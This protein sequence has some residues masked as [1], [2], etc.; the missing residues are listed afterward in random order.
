MAKGIIRFGLQYIISNNSTSLWDKYVLDDTWMEFKM[1]AANYNTINKK[2]LFTDIIK[3]NPAAEKLH[4]AVS[5]AAI[6]YI[7][8]L[9][10][11]MPGVLNAHGK[12]LV[13]F[14]NFTFH[15]IQSD[16][17]DSSLHKV[18]IIFISEP[19]TLID[20]FNAHY[21]IT[22][23]DKQTELKEGKEVPTEMIPCLQ[24]LSIYSFINPI[25]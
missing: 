22:M 10:G 23:G 16:M 18:E 14:K 12:N 20:I 8:Q 15:I 17:N 7:R 1:Q 19:V 21:L 4:Y 9:N 3:E 6:G 2:T 11:M 24:Q 5:T 13:P 25:E